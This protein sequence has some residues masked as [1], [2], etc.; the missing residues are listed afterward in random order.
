MKGS[1]RF[2]ND[3]NVEVSVDP[4]AE[5]GAKLESAKNLVD[6]QELGTGGGAEPIIINAIDNG[7]T[8]F[9]AVDSPSIDTLIEAFNSG[10]FIYINVFNGDV[11]ELSMMVISA[12]IVS[13]ALITIKDDGLPCSWTPIND[14]QDPGIHFVYD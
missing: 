11:L 5:S 14:S 8:A 12:D 10:A 2:N 3:I 4:S 6:G 13:G 9:E 1:I 7:T